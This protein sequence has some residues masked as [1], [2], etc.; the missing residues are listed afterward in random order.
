MEGVTLK[1]KVVPIRRVGL[2]I[3][4]GTAPLFSTVL[5]LALPAKIAGCREIV[6]CTPPNREGKVHPAILYAAEL[7]SVDAVYKVGGAQAIGALAYGTE[8]IG[9]VDKIF[10]PGNRFVTAAADLSESI[11]LEHGSIWGHYDPETNVLVPL[12]ST[13]DISGTPTSKSVIIRVEEAASPIAPTQTSY[14]PLGGRPHRRT[15]FRPS[16]SSLQYQRPSGPLMTRLVS[17]S[18]TTPKLS[19]NDPAV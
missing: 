18:E 7:C 3:P 4:G 15:G 16:A 12:D 14:D 17:P 10:G 9:R 5:M 19:G 11:N 13:A 1:R 6:L 8:T 2:Y